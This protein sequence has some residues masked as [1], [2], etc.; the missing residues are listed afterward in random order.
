M[1]VNSWSGTLSNDD[2]SSQLRFLLNP[3][4]PPCDATF[5]QQEITAK[6]LFSGMGRGGET[7]T[8]DAS[9]CGVLTYMGGVITLGPII[10][11]QLA[12]SYG[13]QLRI[14]QTH[15]NTIVESWKEWLL[16]GGRLHPKVGIWRWCMIFLK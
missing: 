16:L 5:P 9:M 1:V 10:P 6:D 15:L 2:I 13:W 7:L 11:K 3:R 4:G 12:N 14:P 8:H